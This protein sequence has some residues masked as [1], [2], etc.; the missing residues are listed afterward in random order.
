MAST[1]EHLALF[2]SEVVWVQKKRPAQSNDRAARQ[3]TQIALDLFDGR[4]VQGR[5][6]AVRQHVKTIVSK[7]PEVMVKITGSNPSMAGF[8]RSVDY[9]SRSGKYKHK[10]EESL[11]LED[12]RGEIYRGLEGREMLRRAWT[13]A[14]PSIPQESG[15]APGADPKSAPR[16]VLKIIYSMPAHVGRDQVS[17]AAKAAIKETFGRHQWVIAHHADTDNQHT[18]LLIKMVDLD[19]KRMNPRKADLQDWRLS[20]AKQL[21]ARGIEAAATKRSVRLKREKGVSHAVREL[22]ARGQVPERDKTAQPQAAAVSKAQEKEAR[23][24]NAY[25]G[26]AQALGASA[27]ASDR[28]LGRSLE[29]ALKGQGHTVGVSR[30]AQGPAL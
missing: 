24:L 26:I 3:A 30:P 19:G 27:L 17:A 1:D 28:E 11:E 8:M 4:A 15:V 20:F 25:A 21:N 14:G 23:V 6:N 2:D 9:I 7:H 10:G 12:E 13:M 29:Q 18:H 5:A 22:R 16:Q